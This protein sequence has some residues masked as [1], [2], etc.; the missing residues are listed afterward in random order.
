MKKC[1]IAASVALAVALVMPIAAQGDGVNLLENPGFEDGLDGWQTFGNVFAES[2]N[3]PMFEPFEGDGL[4]S[5]FGNFSGGFNVSGLFQEF[6]A[7]PGSEWT[8]DVYS[9]HFSGDSLIGNGPDASNWVVQKLAFKNAADEEIGA[10]ESIILTGASPTD[11][12]I[13]NDAIVGI[14]PD[15]TVQVEALF[16]YLQPAFDGG[17]AHLDNAVLTPEPTIAAFLSLG[18]LVALRRRQR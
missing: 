11:T 14:A 16:L 10:A 7:A 1:T 18:A 5:T 2:S 6:A 8:L 13:D 3:P 12:W 15:G 9:R 4:V 17:A